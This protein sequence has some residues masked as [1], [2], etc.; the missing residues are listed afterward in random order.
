MPQTMSEVIT[1]KVTEGGRIVIPAKLRETLGIEIGES[2]SMRIQDNSLQITTQREAL[3]RLRELVRTRV[4]EGVSLVDELIKE[5][6]E[7]AANE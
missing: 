7:E 4:P 1:T 2:V 5:R 6:R 3:R